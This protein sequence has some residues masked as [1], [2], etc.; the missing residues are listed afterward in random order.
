MDFST[1]RIGGAQG[2]NMIARA[3]VVSMLAFI[4]LT[5]VF[6]RL[7]HIH[8]QGFWGD[9]AHTAHYVAGYL[10]ADIQEAFQHHGTLTA[11][12]LHHFEIVGD[13]RGPADTIRGL[14][15]EDAGHPPLYY[16]L[17]QEWLRL[18]GGS[19]DN[20]RL[21]TALLSL[22]LLPA[23][24]WLAL[25]LF[26][27][28]TIAWIATC[29]VAISPFWL[30]YAQQARE[31]TVWAILTAVSSALLLRALRTGNRWTWAFYS[32]S[33][34][35]N[36]YCFLFAIF[37]VLAH[38]AFVGIAYAARRERRELFSFALC[39]GAAVA[40]YAPWLVAVMA[41]MGSQNPYH[42]NADPRFIQGTNLQGL[43]HTWMVNLA[44][45]FFDLEYIDARLFVIVVGLIALIAW[46][47]ISL[48]RHA[49]PSNRLFIACLFVAPLLVF[50]SKGVIADATRYAIPALLAIELTVAFALDRL[51]ERKRPAAVAC[52]AV[53]L[54]LGV[55]SC[56]VRSQQHTWWI[57]AYG[58]GLEPLSAVVNRS[59]DPLILTD[60][61]V[62]ALD[63]AQFLAP[64][65]RIKLTT[66]QTLERIRPGQED[67]FLYSRSPD[68]AKRY[69]HEYEL[70]PVPI[71]V[72]RR[73]SSIYSDMLHRRAN[74]VQSH[75]T[76]TWLWRVKP[77]HNVANSS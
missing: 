76:I 11:E 55:A 17:G 12:Q 60:D 74:G 65:T 47:A 14:A 53:L 31:Y 16:I 10:V 24:Y 44:A 61:Y 70:V 66:A 13:A 15:V 4:I 23:I 9:E 42:P 71:N 34:A 3:A 28:R 26:G 48:A 54:V 37:V 46:S 21:L 18:V 50:L 49:T 67:V 7:Y 38:A 73:G 20:L 22:L 8:Q 63:S 41:Y 56:I 64:M 1:P 35:L 6:L 52:F 19:P 59:A 27:S 68:L 30:E 77:K 32:L 2:A 36:L 69:A 58:A 57:T 39:I 40:L 25:Q 75:T 5:G 29:L 33:V 51:I 72:P 45:P 43:V 62:I